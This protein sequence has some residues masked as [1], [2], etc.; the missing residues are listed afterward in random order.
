MRASALIEE[1]RQLIADHGDLPITLAVGSY[2][3]SAN[4]IG[5]AEEGPLPN[6][7]DI[8]GQSSDERFVI[9]AKDDI[10]DLD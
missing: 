4:N 9:E 10:P 2:E 5:H 7:R 3:Y 8:Q 6:I 1:L